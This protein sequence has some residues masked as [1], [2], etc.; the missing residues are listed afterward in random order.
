MSPFRNQREQKKLTSSAT[1]PT[2]S[3]TEFL[4]KTELW[5][6]CWIDLV[7]LDWYHQSKDLKPN[8]NLNKRCHHKGKIG[9]HNLVLYQIGSHNNNGKTGPPSLGR[10]RVGKLG[11]K[12]GLLMIGIFGRVMTQNKTD[13]TFPISTFRSLM[14]NG[15]STPTISTQ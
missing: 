6:D 14:E 1:S 10:P 15:K 7:N 2:F 8:K 12:T 5:T 4:Q 9:H 11:G 13:P 3:R